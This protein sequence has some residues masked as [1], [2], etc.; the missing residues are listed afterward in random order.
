MFQVT[1]QVIAQVGAPMDDAAALPEP[2]EEMP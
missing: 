2:A 1:T